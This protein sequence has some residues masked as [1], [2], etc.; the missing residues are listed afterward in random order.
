MEVYTP[1]GYGELAPPL[2]RALPD[3][4][5]LGGGRR[6]GDARRGDRQGRRQADGRRDRRRGDPD[7]VVRAVERRFRVERHA[8]GRAI[9]GGA[10]VLDALFR[11]PG[12]FGNASVWGEGWSGRI[13]R[14]AAVNERTD[15]LE[16]R[17]GRDDPD[18]AALTATRARLDRHGVNY[19]YGET[20]AGD[21]RRYLMEL[22]P[23]LFRE[24]ELIEP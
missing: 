17:I 20:A 18:Y 1:P 15:T 2:P 9:A 23:R 8:G 16:L 3:R 21:D 12:L 14:V 7:D 22:V 6:E 5:R 10:V 24:S 11:D 13:A 4:R 19:E